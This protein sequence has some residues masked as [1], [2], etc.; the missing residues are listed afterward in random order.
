MSTPSSTSDFDTIQQTQTPPRSHFGFLRPRITH[1]D[2]SF[3]SINLPFLSQPTSYQHV[4]IRNQQNNGSQSPEGDGRSSRTKTSIFKS[5]EHRLKHSIL[6]GSKQKRRG[7]IVFH[8]VISLIAVIFL[9]LPILSYNLNGKEVD[10]TGDYGKRILNLIQYGPTIFPIIFAAITGHF[11]RSIALR[12]AERGTTLEMLEQLT[13]SITIASTVTT[14]YLLNSYN[15]LSAVLLCLWAIS[16]LGGQASLR[17]LK[18]EFVEIQTDIT[19]N[20]LD[21]FNQSSFLE[22]GADVG[23]SLTES[24]NIYVSSL[25]SSAEVKNSPIDSWRNVKIPLLESFETNSSAIQGERGWY[26]VPLGNVTY[27]SLLGTPISNRTANFTT[28]IQ[29][30]YAT[31]E[32]SSLEII[33]PDLCNEG[34][35]TRCFNTSNPRITDW[36]FPAHPT[37]GDEG[38]N[39]LYIVTGF[40][41]T[42]T[43]LNI[44]YDRTTPMDLIIQSRGESG[45]S[46][47]HCV[48]SQTFV[49]VQVDC[50][51]TNCRASKIRR[52]ET[53]P[54]RPPVFVNAPNFVLYNFFL[55]FA[56]VTPSGHV[57]YSNPSQLYVLFPEN[58]LS[59]QA[60]WLDLANAGKELFGA[61][62]TQLI[63]TF[64]SS[65]F[66]GGLYL[67]SIPI[68]F[69]STK[70]FGRQPLRYKTS[71]AMKTELKHIYVVQKPWAS[72]TLLASLLLLAMGIAAA[73]ISFYT[74][75]PDVL[76]SLSALA[77]ESPWFDTYKEGTTLDGDDKAV[78]LKRRLV[79]LG[80][81]KRFEEVGY[82][83]LGTVDTEVV[84]VGRLSTDRSYR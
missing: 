61:R 11:L 71:K 58:P 22:I 42:Q 83:A 1:I 35:S 30:G 8:F 7:E 40:N 63:N 15:F 32:C 80:D 76:T 23:L 64:L 45:N 60:E 2:K 70:Q 54:K 34:R 33:D 50:L 79:R 65:T 9:V 46:V 21:P 48:L 28:I 72:I 55:W 49:E 18:T 78:A 82:I 73:A 43:L 77:N 29:S 26:N 27:S 62:M 52:L 25:L 12:L 67:G 47:G 84:N 51:S 14:P 57:G 13:R 4:D 36:V 39:A 53:G 38:A 37:E 68:G 66:G 5:D 3:S 74:L 6:R 81:V 31:I 17:I 41:Q 69:N 75:A 56:R 10:E 20:Y 19:S 44:T 16:P 24:N 59:M